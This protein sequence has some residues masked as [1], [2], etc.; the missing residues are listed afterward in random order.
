MNSQDKDFIDNF[1]DFFKP[2]HQEGVRFLAVTIC[3]ILLFLFGLFISPWIIRQ[4]QNVLPFTV[5]FLQLSP[6]EVLFNYIKIGFFFSFFITMPVFIYQFGKLKIEKDVFEQRIN[7][8]Y[9]SLGVALII[10]ASILLSYFFFY[11][12]QITFLY[13]LNFD[14]AY[15]SSSLSAIVT[16]FILTIFVTVML[17]LLPL[18]RNLIKKSMLFNYATFVQ[19]RKPVIAYSAIFSA[20]IVLPMELMA[21]CAVFLVFFFWYKILVNFSKKRD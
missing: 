1:L 17:A 15:F 9:F 7:L 18:L 20:L 6:L 19:Y 8:L 11:P 14:V 2:Y 5:E 10:F 21:L 12:W 3:F 13:G 4:L 16:T